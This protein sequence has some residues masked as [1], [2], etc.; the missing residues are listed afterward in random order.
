MKYKVEL[1]VMTVS[2]E[3]K[4]IEAEDLEDAEFQAEQE[5]AEEYENGEQL[6]LTE[7]RNVTEL[8]EEEYA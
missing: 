5:F 6:I 4:E 8:D 1:K 7:V 2:F 3:Y